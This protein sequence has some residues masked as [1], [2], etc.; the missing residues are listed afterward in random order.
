MCSNPTV[1]EAFAWDARGEIR[2]CRGQLEPLLRL[3]PEVLVDEQ[4]FV[5]TKILFEIIEVVHTYNQM[6]WV[7]R[8]F[9]AE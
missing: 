8:S 5:A 2:Y 4:V 3:I 1:A 7:R 9:F 6:L